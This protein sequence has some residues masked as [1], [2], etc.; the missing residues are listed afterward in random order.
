MMKRQECLQALAENRTN[1]VVLS[2]MT[3]AGEWGAVSSHELDMPV[4]GAM[5]QV[6]DIGLGIALAQPSR[7]VVVLN[8]DGSMLMNLGSLV[9][10]IN[11]A[12]ANYTLMV[13]QNGV[14]EIT[15]GQPLPGLGKFSFAELAR[16]AG[17]RKVYE[18]EELPA[19][20]ADIP[21]LL[22][23][24]GPIF[25]AL[26]VEGG[27]VPASPRPSMVEVADRMRS[28]LTGQPARPVA[29]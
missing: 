27:P 1:E 26:K 13:V 5:G 6:P 18:Y 21:T 19:F 17:F 15:G 29:E 24:E 3:A 2:T 9:T 12:P 4:T 11:A 14:Y 22:K 28:V 7:R 8:G 20:R 10:I 25:A 23:E 16:A